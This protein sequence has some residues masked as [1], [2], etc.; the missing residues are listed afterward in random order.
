MNVSRTRGLLLACLL[1]AGCRQTPPADQGKSG[2]PADA[3]AAIRFHVAQLGPEDQRWAEQQKYC[4]IMPDVRLGEMGKPQKVVL[5][6]VTVFL[7]CE[8]CLEVV[9]EDPDK[10]LAQLKELQEA[11]AKELG[12]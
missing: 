5:K 7:C 12:E 10:A 3:E 6:G 4:P 9:Q 11:R 8:R 2:G 1:T